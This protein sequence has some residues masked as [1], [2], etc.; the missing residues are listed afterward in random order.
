LINKPFE[1]L[2]LDLSPLYDN[3]W[4]S[5]FSEG[6]ATFQI[7]MTEP[8]ELKNIKYCHISTT[9]ELCQSRIDLTLFENYK[10]VMESISNFLLSKLELIKLTKFDRSGKQSA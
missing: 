4:L 2:P 8:S 5:G 3:A 1:K 6:E 9:Y 7:R 10:P